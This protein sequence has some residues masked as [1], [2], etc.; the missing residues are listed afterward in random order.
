[1]EIIDKIAPFRTLSKRDKK[2]REK[3]WI[4]KGILQS[5]RIKNNLYNRYIRKHDQFWYHR[6]NFYRSKVN[7]LISKS[8]KNYLRSYFQENS[9]NSKKPWT[10]I[11][12]I[13]QKNKNVKNGILLSKKGL[14]ISDQKT[15]AN[16]FKN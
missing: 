8:K 7:M 16:K 13:L 12:Q 5:I 9:K 3:S 11:N 1:M 14:I 4:T 2:L 15:V 10:K 6:Y